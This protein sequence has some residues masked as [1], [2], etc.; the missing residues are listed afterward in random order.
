MPEVGYLR[1]YG[2]TIQA[3]AA[4]GHE[5]RLAFNK[6]GERDGR[7]Y[8]G[9]SL[10]GSTVA[11]VGSPPVHAGPWRQPLTD[12]GCSIDYV[13]FLSMQE[14][15]P[16]LRRRM[17]K[18]LPAHRRHLQHAQR[19]P[20]WFV[21][22]LATAARMAESSVPPDPALVS[23]IERQAPDAVVVSPLVM[24]GPGG[25][26]QTQLVKAAHALGLPVALAVGSWDHLSSKGLVRV[27]PEQVL[28]WNDVQKRESVEMHNLDS[29]RVVI[30]GAQLFDLWF[31]R[32]PALGREA[33]LT[34]VGL[35]T[36]R[37]MLLYAGSSRG[38]ADP[39]LEVPFVRQWLEALRSTPDEVL[40]TASVLVR[41]HLSNV[42]AW[43]E[44]DL[45]AFGPV[46]VFP[47]ERPSLPMN[48]LETSDYFHSLYHSDLVMGLNTSAMIE[49]VIL[50]RP[51]LTVE[52]PVF[53][54]SQA[55]TA[56]FHYLT[57]GGRGPVESA[58]TLHGHLRQAS[59]ALAQQGYRRPERKR[60]I[61]TFVRPNGVDR[62]ALESVIDALETLPEQ[63]V[64]VP[65]LCWW[66]RRIA[67][68]LLH[69]WA[70][71]GR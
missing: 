37:P 56:H 52:L 28:V 67:Q 65:R 54:D 22:V 69:R 38:I 70:A 24:R 63:A 46:S 59:R 49:A 26:Q 15:T 27:T 68:P 36:D 48:E 62:P 14:G 6:T 13:R 47:R 61:E 32:T 9:L 4:R 71:A 55:G 60:F 35:P 18:Y 42:S 25:V 3:L 2:T 51:V 58:D 53:A 12:L 64:A 10:L 34:R 17:A 8:S 33:F 41:P 21:Q 23:F 44:V 43:A 50:D 57:S 1:I 19:W 66:H 45:S 31:G 30:T 11:S 20:S 40:R 16:Y 7:D 5:V 39:V 29:S